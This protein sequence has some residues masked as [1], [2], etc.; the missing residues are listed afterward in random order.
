M[1]PYISWYCYSAVYTFCPKEI[2]ITDLAKSDHLQ[3]SNSPRMELT[4]YIM[5]YRSYP[6]LRI[7]GIISI[8]D[9]CGYLS[10]DGQ[11]T[12]GQLTFQRKGPLGTW[13]PDGQSIAFV[14]SVDSKPQS[15]SFLWRRRSLAID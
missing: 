2:Q 13:A 15:L 11:S 1:K 6:I 4:Y 8:N 14:R 12:S 7:N 9:N 10:G 3:C 5:S